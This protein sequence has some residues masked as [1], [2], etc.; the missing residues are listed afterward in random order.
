MY[1]CVPTWFMPDSHRG[2]KEG[3]GS[4]G[5]GDTNSCELL[6]YARTEYRS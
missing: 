4:P 5:T 6:L 3:V 1:I 2:Q